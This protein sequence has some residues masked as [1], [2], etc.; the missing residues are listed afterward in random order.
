MKKFFKMSP[1]INL[2]LWS[3][4]EYSQMTNSEDRHV[5]SKPK[6]LTSLSYKTKKKKEKEEL[7][8]INKMKGKGKKIKN[9]QSFTTWQFSL[10]A[11]H[12]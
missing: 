8:K 11:Q 2:I 10:Q 6:L 5:Q 1:W 7:K 3:E 9:T 4:I 12:N